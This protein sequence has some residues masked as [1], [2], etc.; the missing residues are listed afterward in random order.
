MTSSKP[1]YFPR[2]HLLIPSRWGLGFQHSHFL[3]ETNIRSTT[4]KLRVGPELSYY[5][6]LQVI[7]VGITSIL[8]GVYI[9]SRLVF[10][11]PVTEASVLHTTIGSA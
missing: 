7:L 4:E 6:W 2:A 5:P 9:H 11:Y 1:N 10:A 3:G 8:P